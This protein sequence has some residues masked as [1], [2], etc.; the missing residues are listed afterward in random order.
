MLCVC[1]CMCVSVKRESEHSKHYT[2]L[3]SERHNA[4]SDTMHTHVLLDVL[5][6]RRACAPV[7]HGFKCHSLPPRR[8]LPQR[9]VGSLVQLV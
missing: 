1:V 2:H 6:P 5:R 9:W 4:A 3:R 7:Y 8:M